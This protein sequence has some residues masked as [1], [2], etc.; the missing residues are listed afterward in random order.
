MCY[1]VYKAYAMRSHCVVYKAYAGNPNA[2]AKIV[3]VATRLLS[4]IPGIHTFHA[5]K[6]LNT[7][8]AVGNSEYDVLLNIIFLDSAAC[9]AYMSNMNH[10]KFV[11]FVLKGYML[12]GSRSANPEQEF[13]EHILHGGEPQA[14]VRNPAVSDDQVVWGGEVVFD[15]A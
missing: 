6:I 9:E 15:A 5:A 7:G 14:W 12:E 11:E 3:E 2:A 1:V 13:I 10:R 4:I 8:R